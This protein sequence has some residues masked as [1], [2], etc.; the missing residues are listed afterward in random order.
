M[1][2]FD[3]CRDTYFTNYICNIILK[4][5]TFT[6]SRINCCLINIAFIIVAIF[7]IKF[8]DLAEIASELGI[9]GY[10]TMDKG[11]LTARQNGSVGGYFNIEY[12]NK[13]LCMQL[14]VHCY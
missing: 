4:V 3:V 10:D 7:L 11:N 6:T 5:I 13:G 8:S 1:I 2:T 9:S 14:T 12:I